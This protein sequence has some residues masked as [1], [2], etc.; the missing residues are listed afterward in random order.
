MRGTHPSASWTWDEGDVGDQWVQIDVG[1]T[2]LVT[3]LV[4]QGGDDRNVMKK[5]NIKYSED[6]DTWNF[7]KN[8]NGTEVVS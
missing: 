3:G 8:A 7:V 2:K 5:F 1:D 4:T 6:G